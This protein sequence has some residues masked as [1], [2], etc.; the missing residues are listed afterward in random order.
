MSG[1]T[2]A[3][4]IAAPIGTAIVRS[5]ES[6]GIKKH[7]RIAPPVFKIHQV[8]KKSALHDRRGRS[9]RGAAGNRHGGNGE[10]SDGDDANSLHDED[11]LSVSTRPCE[12]AAV[13]NSQD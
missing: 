2:D 9:L 11:P 5:R 3:P 1:R 13:K 6:K 4:V 8:L 10:E 12:R 7:R